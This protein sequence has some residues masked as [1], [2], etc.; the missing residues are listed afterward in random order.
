MLLM[1]C[2]IPGKPS[3]PHVW[4]AKT[5]FTM[6]GVLYNYSYPNKNVRLGIVTLS[7]FIWLHFCKLTWKSM[8]NVFGPCVHFISTIFKSKFEVLFWYILP[9]IIVELMSHWSKIFL[10]TNYFIIQSMIAKNGG[11]SSKIRKISVIPLCRIQ[12]AQSNYYKQS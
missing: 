10:S 7:L 2:C 6:F 9:E 4:D 8:K 5:T 3:T 11:V 12:L 1:Y